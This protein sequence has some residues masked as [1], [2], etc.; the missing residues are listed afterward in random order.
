MLRFVLHTVWGL[1]Q[2]FVGRKHEESLLGDE[3]EV[4]WV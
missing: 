4:A 1:W 2:R 3:E